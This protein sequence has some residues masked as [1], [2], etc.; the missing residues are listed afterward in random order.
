MKKRLIKPLL[1]KLNTEPQFNEQSNAKDI[2][3]KKQ[4]ISSDLEHN[5]ATFKSIFSIPE[6]MDVKLREI[7]I[8][9]RNRRA[10]I[11]FISTMTDVANVQESIV[12]PLLE[13]EQ[14]TGKIQ[15]IVS[16]PIEKTT[17]NIGGII[18]FITSG[19]TAVFVDGDAECYLFETTQTR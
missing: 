1:E 6:N 5:L 8:R 13:D 12:E 7:T 19:M 3:R 15:D 4:D 11:L 2:E 18:D 14:P 10:F 16:Y 17:S 9:A